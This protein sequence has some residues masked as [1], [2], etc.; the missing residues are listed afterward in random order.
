MLIN[1]MRRYNRDPAKIDKTIARD[2]ARILECQL[3]EETELHKLARD[4]KFVEGVFDDRDFCRA[5]ADPRALASIDRTI[6]DWLRLGKRESG[7]QGQTVN[8]NGPTQVVFQTS[9]L[10]ALP[11]DELIPLEGAAAT[12]QPAGEG[13]RGDG[14]GGGPANSNN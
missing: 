4:R 14:N 3:A 2:K 6:G 13:G 8:L 9:S 5:A 1:P 12:A 10:A 11:L 7:D